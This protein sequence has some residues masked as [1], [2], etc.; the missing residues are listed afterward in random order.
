[1]LLSR[2]EVELKNSNTG[3]YLAML[4]ICNKGTF[5]DLGTVNYEHSTEKDGPG[6]LLYASIVSV[7]RKG[8]PP[9]SRPQAAWPFELERDLQVVVVSNTC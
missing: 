5:S 4:M 1:M 6:V 8:P 7:L 2:L 9:T 3:S